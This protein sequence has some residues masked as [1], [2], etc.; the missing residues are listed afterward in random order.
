MKARKIRL[1]GD[2]VEIYIHG[3]EIEEVEPDKYA[4]MLDH[5]GCADIEITK[6][7]RTI[8]ILVHSE[9]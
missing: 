6:G 1:C 7:E 5:L 3:G 4:V 9:T 2:V 8:T